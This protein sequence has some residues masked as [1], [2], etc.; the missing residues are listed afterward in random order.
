M[1]YFEIAPCFITFVR[2]A[3][4]RCWK[5]ARRRRRISHESL[6][7]SRAHGAQFPAAARSARCPGPGGRAATVSGIKE[8]MP[9]D[10]VV[11]EGSR[12]RVHAD[13]RDA[14]CGSAAGDARPGQLC[15]HHRQV[16]TVRVLRVGV[17]TPRWPPHR[18]RCGR[19]PGQAGRLIQCNAD[20]IAS[21]RAWPSIIDRLS[22]CVWFFPKAAGPDGRLVQAPTLPSP[23]RPA[24]LAFA[25][26]RHSPWCW[27]APSPALPIC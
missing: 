22:F 23:S 17:P 13:R 12:R 3:G 14:A 5:V 20:C 6:M 1:P 26:L 15:S 11:V 21:V 2:N 9:A 4:G 27:E 10:G 18:A 7:N 16:V 24:P 8:K 19:R 25:T